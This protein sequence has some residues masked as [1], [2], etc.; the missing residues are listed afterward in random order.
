MI[1]V[2]I[3][4]DNREELHNFVEYFG[5]ADD[6]KVVGTARNGKE[7]LAKL[8]TI[9][10]D[11]IISDIHM[12]CMGGLELLKE[13]RAVGSTA[14]FIAMT[15]LDTDNGMI[16]TLAGGGSGYITKDQRPELIHQAVRDSLNG[17]TSVSAEALARLLSYVPLTSEYGPSGNRISL[18]GTEREIL[19]QLCKGL[20]NHEIA[21]ETVY[22]ESTVKRHISS[23]MT[24]F[25]VNSRLKLALAALRI[26]FESQGN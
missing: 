10:A 20:S 14:K 5:F 13:L 24:K 1:S 25:D 23:L 11:V 15:G 21:E 22:S 19:R 9:R 7:A 6:I 8:S 26:D 4:E 16:A 17:G 2:F 12:P 18:N 3:V